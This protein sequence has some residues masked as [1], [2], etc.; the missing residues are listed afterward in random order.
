MASKRIAVAALVILVLAGCSNSV[1]GRQATAKVRIKVTYKGNAVEGATVTLTN[2]EANTTGVGTTG[3][4]G[5]CTLTTFAS[6]DGVV[7]GPQ[8]AAVRRVDLIDRS[9]PGFDYGASSE[10]PPPPE[11]R[12]IVPKKF[13]DPKTSDLKLTIEP[14]DGKE[15]RLEF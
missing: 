15:Y 6:G 11:E 8:I 4:D 13:A 5:V 14:T 10:V 3:A 9:K 2:T 12:W 7:P 1:P